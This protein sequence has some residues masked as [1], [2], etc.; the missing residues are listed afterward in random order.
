M[1]Q[2]FIALNRRKRNFY[3]RPEAVFRDLLEEV[4]KK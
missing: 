2:L 1:E 4:S 3:D